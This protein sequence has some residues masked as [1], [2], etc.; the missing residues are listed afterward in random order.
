MVRREDIT[1]ARVILAKNWLSR[2]EI[3]R[4][5]RDL[6]KLREHDPH[7]TFGHYL[8][9]KE[10]L[11]WDRIERARRCIARRAAE[12]GTMVAVCD[13]DKNVRDTAKAAFGSTPRH[14]ENCSNAV[15]VRRT[16]IVNRGAER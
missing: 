7:L 15:T 4:A 13:V 5:L 16:A 1:L 8:G 11:S 14:F 9:V 3:E 6:V 2:E 12:L 10:I